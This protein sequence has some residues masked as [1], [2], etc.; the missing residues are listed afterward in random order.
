MK[1]LVQKLLAP[2]AAAVLCTASFAADKIPVTASFSILGDLVRVVGGERVA[3]TSLVGP[4]EDAHVFEPKP[5]D[6][7]TI[8]ASK[9]LVTNGLGFEPWAQKL[10]KSA[11]YKG[12]SVVAS[13][14]VKGRT[15]TDEK[16]RPEADPHAWQDPTNVVL[17]VRNIAAALGQVDPAGASAYQANS[18]A[19]VQELQTLDSWA[20]EQFAAIP[21]PKRKVITSHDAF[22]YFAAHYQLQF[23]APQGVSTEAEPSA[24]EV[25]KLI[26]QIQRE[27]I[28]AVFMEN[29][30]NPKL[31]AQLSKDA[32][33][34][35][36]ASLYADALS[37]PGQP[38]TTY[39]LMARHN[40]S[41]L[42]LGMQNN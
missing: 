42:A 27:K 31:L 15:L 20:K 13:K 32:G 37:G 10:A 19:Y 30:S 3:V 11:G 35:L 33:V 4:D 38:G 6:A 41:Q 9:L 39:L 5:S 12:A 18:E 36:G 23:L 29:M 7:K 22:G 25:A 8:L 24:K 16:G 28:K 1:T 26:K 40:V 2:L 17:Y 14:G 34:T 21:A